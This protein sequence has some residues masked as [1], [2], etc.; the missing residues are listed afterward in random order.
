ML[1]KSLRMEFPEL[2]RH[3]CQRPSMWVR[4]PGFSSVCAYIS[5]FDHARDGGPLDGFREWLVVRLRDGDNM[6]WDGLVEM[7][8][9]PEADPIESATDDQDASRLKAMA[10]LFDEFFRFRDEEGV[11]KIHYEYARWLIRK[12]RFTGTPR[13]KRE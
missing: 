13:K 8:I 1:R 5:G 3:M 7:A 2:V 6:T 9:R 4:P 11:T 12:R 10:V